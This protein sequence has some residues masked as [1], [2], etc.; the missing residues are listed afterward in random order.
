M[1]YSCFCC[2]CCFSCVHTQKTNKQKRY[3]AARRGY[4]IDHH[5]QREQVTGFIY[6]KHDMSQN[7]GCSY[8]S[9]GRR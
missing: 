2:S 6:I 5:D 9:I 1:G 4:V 3:F 8:L 7:E